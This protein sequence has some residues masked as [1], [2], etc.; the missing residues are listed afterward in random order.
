[1]R[2]GLRRLST[3]VAREADGAARLLQGAR[4]LIQPHRVDKASSTRRHSVFSRSRERSLSSSKT[5]LE[6]TKSHSHGRLKLSI[7]NQAD[8]A[9]IP[10]TVGQSEGW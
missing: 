8:A 2:V 10:M 1:M 6:L 7:T 9:N 5:A 4:P 3:A